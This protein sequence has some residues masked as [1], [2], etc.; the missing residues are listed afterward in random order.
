MSISINNQSHMQ[1]LFKT[2]TA[3]GVNQV[4]QPLPAIDNV[5]APKPSAM[6]D[7]KHLRY[8]SNIKPEEVA[9]HYESIKTAASKELDET[10]FGN[11]LLAPNDYHNATI[12]KIMAVPIEVKIDRD[13]VNTAI[14]YNRL[15]ISFLDVKRVEVRMEI[16]NLAQTEVDNGADKGLIRKDQQLALTKKI[17]ENLEKLTAQRQSLLDRNNGDESEEVFL[18]QLEQQRSIKL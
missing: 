8:I 3:S 11:K 18:V 9:A 4:K 14:L 10:N 17:D 1:A 12:D 15:G 2:N 13:E 5:A 6:T 16:L 7:I